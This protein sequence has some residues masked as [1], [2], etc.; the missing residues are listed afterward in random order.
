ML[1]LAGKNMVVI[2]GSRGVGRRIVE[3]AIGSG[4]RVL[5]VAR[6]EGP[7]RQLAQEVSGTEV[8]SLDAT[9]QGAPARVFGVLEPDILV[10]CAGAFP[11]AAP[12]HK[13]SWQEFAINWEV[14]VKIAFHFCKAALSR[15]LREGAS[16][17]LISSGAALAGSPNSG[18][19]A[20]AKRTQ[21]F[22][23]NYSQKESDRLELGLRFMTLAP[24]MM[25]DTDL[26]R[27][28]VA[29]YSRYLGISEADFVQS[30][31]SPP[32]SFDTASAVIKLA[33]G[34]QQS[35]GKVFVVSGEGL[36]AVSL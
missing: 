22:I 34:P 6:Q 20:G 7:L 23:A 27:H 14:D 35:L 26:G 5:A 17:I 3:A 28:A 32:T 8:L 13:L 25:P 15:P 33:A 4:A 18:G 10:L 29:G 36:E 19:Y 1:S 30:M 2:G 11:S 9:D 16:V 12:L 24:R 31:V 21:M